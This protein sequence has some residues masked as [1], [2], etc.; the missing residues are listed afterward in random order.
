MVQAG[1]RIIDRG[2]IVKY[3][4]FSILNSLKR[5]YLENVDEKNNNWVMLG[6][7]FLIAGLLFIFSLYIYLFRPECI[8]I[9]N[10]LFFILMLV[11]I[12]GSASL[13]LK[14]SKQSINIVPFALLA[15]IVRIFFDSRTA[16]FV[17]IVTVL[18][19]SLFVQSSY[20]FV[21]LHITAGMA[22]VSSLKQLTRRSQLVKSALLIFLTYSFVYLFFTLIDS[23]APGNIQ[24]QPFAVFAGNAV[25]LLFAYILIYIFERIFGY[26]SDVTLVELS[27]INSKLLMEFSLKA[28]GSFQHVIQVSTLAAAAASKINA[29]TLLARTGALYHDIGK[30]K[31]PAIYTENQNLSGYKPLDEKPLDEA[32]QMI[33]SHVYDGVKIAE[34][35]GLPAKIIAFIR[36]HHAKSVTRYFY[37]MAVNSDGGDSVDAAKFTYPGPLPSTKEEAIVMMAD[38]VEAASHSLKEY[39]EATVDALV[40]NIV[41]LQIAEHSFKNAPIT[42]HDVEAVKQVLKDK[43]LNIYHSRIAYPELKSD[44]F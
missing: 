41:N 19:V 25:L 32:A 15:I 3:Q 30:M 38:A 6:E 11:M 8:S 27:N 24:M 29:N 21:L 22:A 42:F 17:H 40:E 9:K 4:Q 35:H 2:E 31:N 18:M 5:E 16:L 10:A 44:K 43:L 12:I 13:M 14:Y 28:P 34:H 37:N 39:S 26:L 36:S 33:I 23:G 1:E 7:F 20:L